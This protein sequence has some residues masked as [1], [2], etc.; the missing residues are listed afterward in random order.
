MSKLDRLVVY[1]LIFAIG[2]VLVALIG[3]QAPL[4]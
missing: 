4:R 2:V 1:G 3:C